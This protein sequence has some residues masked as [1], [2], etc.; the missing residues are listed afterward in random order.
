M[1]AQDGIN[2]G[3]FHEKLLAGDG[4]QVSVPRMSI[5]L[6]TALEI[7]AGLEF[8]HTHNI[9]HGDLTAVNVLLASVKSERGKKNFMAKVHPRH[10]LP[11]PL[12]VVLSVSFLVHHAS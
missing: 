9:L 12:C 11:E 1:R 7:A 6:E 5:I 4:Q 10:T 2:T 8:I 3:L